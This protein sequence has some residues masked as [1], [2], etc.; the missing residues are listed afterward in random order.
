MS[1]T[2]KILIKINLGFK[3]SPRKISS[4]IHDDHL[5]T[6][7]PDPASAVKRKIDKPILR[8]DTSETHRETKQTYR[9]TNKNSAR[10]C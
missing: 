4:S 7:E 10:N 8:Y 6:L 3:I 5:K 9:Q 2:C 1:L